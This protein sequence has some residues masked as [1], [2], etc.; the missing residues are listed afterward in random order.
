MQ[1]TAAHGHMDSENS[2]KATQRLQHMTN[3]TL[4]VVFIFV[5]MYWCMCVVSVCALR[6]M[7][8]TSLSAGRACAFNSDV[9]FYSLK[10]LDFL[11]P[12]F[13]DRFPNIIIYAHAQIK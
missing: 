2:G 13:S 5:D 8:L 9:S 1:S 3:T 7:V 10:F 4:W 6:H 12:F 11:Y